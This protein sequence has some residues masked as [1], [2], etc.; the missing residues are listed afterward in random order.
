MA[1]TCKHRSFNFGWSY[2]RRLG[3]NL[4]VD[5]EQL[6][7]G[8]YGK[9]PYTFKSE[10]GSQLLGDFSRPV[11]L[12]EALSFFD[13]ENLPE[14]LPDDLKR[15]ILEYHKGLS[16]FGGNGTQSAKL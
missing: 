7:S 8:A 1:H 12:V 11:D 6:Q 5:A 4:G 3:A 16:E 13:L 15:G 10:H 2:E 14:K 9:T